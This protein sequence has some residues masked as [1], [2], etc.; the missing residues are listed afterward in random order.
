[1][2]A[3]V[4]ED[5][6]TLGAMLLRILRAAGFF[7]TWVRDGAAGVEAYKRERPAIVFVDCLL[8]KLGGF[9]VCEQIRALAGDRVGLI[10]MSATFRTA[11]IKQVRGAGADGFM[12]K[13]FVIADV[14]KRAEELAT[15]VTGRPVTA[16]AP[17]GPPGAGAPAPREPDA[18]IGAGARLDAAPATE[19]DQ[20]PIGTAT[21]VDPVAAEER[22]PGEERSLARRLMT[23]SRERPSGTLRIEGEGAPL[24]FTVRD[25]VI[26][27]GAEGGV[28]VPPGLLAA[29]V[30]RTLT[31]TACP[32]RMTVEAAV[33]AG[34]D[35]EPVDLVDAVLTHALADGT[36]AAEAFVRRHAEARAERTLDFDAGLVAFAKHRPQSHLPLALIE[37]AV[38]LDS[39]QVSSREGM[40]D[41]YA[42]WSAGLVRLSTEPAPVR[43]IPRP[44][45][46]PSPTSRPSA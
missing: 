35:T 34:Q 14:R 33:P 2:R 43:P 21:A 7:A 5:D 32:M 1:V 39:V 31:R 25:G 23:L 18:S 36:D 15:R 13:P 30:I 24:T 44:S 9:E 45:R 41:V 22:G 8:P 4:V 10:L 27:G 16:I 6:D 37:G 12:S 40:R 11:S 26:V 38:R 29:A 17:G 20:A 3:L 19:I 28:S 42:L 46:M